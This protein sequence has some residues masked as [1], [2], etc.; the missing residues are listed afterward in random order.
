MEREC[1]FRGTKFS[2]YVVDENGNIYRKS[3][4]R[5]L[6]PFDDKRGYYSVDLMSDNNV[7][8]RCK[9]HMIVAHT[10]LGPQAP[11]MIINHIDANKHNN[12]LKN[13]EYISQ[14]ENVAHAMKFVKK[15]AYLSDDL[16]F[17][18]KTRIKE[19]ERLNRIAIDLGLPL[20]LVY[21]IA[22]GWTYRH[23]TV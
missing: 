12:S 2:K 1:I 3:T 18:I 8:I 14:R 13:L 17:D 4:G 9:V 5:K 23:I 10:F 16:V 20:Y 6:I 22:R 11:D 7:P 19:G 21:D 15:K